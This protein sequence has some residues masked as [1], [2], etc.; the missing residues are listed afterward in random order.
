[1]KTSYEQ[2]VFQF[3]IGKVQQNHSIFAILGFY[4]GRF[5]PFLQSFSQKSRS[6]VFCKIAIFLDFTPFLEIDIWGSEIDRLFYPC[7]T[8]TFT[9]FSII[10][11]R[12]VTL[13][14]Q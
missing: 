1:M 8:S 4:Y 12:L 6:I 5:H 13:I 10:L 14:P 7:T 9:I 2:I 3:L 11:I